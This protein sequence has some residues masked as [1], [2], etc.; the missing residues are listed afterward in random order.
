MKAD[1]QPNRN[2]L[3]PQPHRHLY[4][5]KSPLCFPNLGNQAHVL[6]IVIDHIAHEANTVCSNDL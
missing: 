2:A 1:D 3:P 5:Y 4:S 6:W